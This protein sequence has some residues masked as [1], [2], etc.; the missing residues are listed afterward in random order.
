LPHLGT[1]SRPHETIK[2]IVIK[3]VI[4]IFIAL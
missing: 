2:S 1:T 3:I 4:L